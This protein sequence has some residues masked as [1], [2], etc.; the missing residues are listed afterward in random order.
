[1]DT[2]EVVRVV[3]RLHRMEQRQNHIMTNAENESD[4]IIERTLTGKAGMSAYKDRIAETE[5]RKELELR[6]AQGMC[7]MEPGNRDDERMAVR[8]A[9]VSGGDIDGKTSKTRIE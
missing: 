7:S 3:L 1:M 6:E 9:D 8:H 4:T 2:L 5:T